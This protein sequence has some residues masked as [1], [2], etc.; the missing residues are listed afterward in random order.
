M[1]KPFNLDIQVNSKLQSCRMTQEVQN[2]ITN[3]ASLF[4]RKAF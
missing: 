1:N 4:D 2:K 3:N